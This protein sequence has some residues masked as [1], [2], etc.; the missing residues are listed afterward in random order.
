MNSKQRWDAVVVGAGPNGLSAAVELAHHGGRVLLLEAADRVGGA[1]R[2]EEL[3]LPGFHHDV[4]SA[5]YPL[6][7]GSPFFARLP[8]EEHGLEWIHGSAP[9]AHPLDGGRAVVLER[10][11]RTTALGLGG[12]ARRYGALLDPLVR[13]WPDFAR[14]ILG[15]P[16]TL[17]RDP[18]LMA[19]FG[20]SALWP[21]GAL[22]R[23]RF[24]T[25]EARA[26]FAGN[27]AHAALP[28]DRTPT[29]AIAL[30]LMAAGHAVGW[31]VPRGGAGALTGALASYARSL[32]VAIETGR[33]VAHLSELPPAKSV[34]L[35]LT[36]R[37]VLEVAGDAL[38]DGYRRR[39]EEWRYGP[40]AFK[41]DWALDGPIPWAAD[42]C[43]RA[44][45]IHLGG[46]LR[47]ME[48]AEALPWKGESAERPFVLLAQPTLFDPTR[49]PEGKHTAWAYCHVPNGWR[50]GEEL[51]LRRLE[52]QVERFAPGFRDRIL[53]RSVLG[54]ADLEAWNPNLVGGDIGGGAVT[55]GQTLARPRAFPDPWSTPVPGL[56]ICS[57]ST[58]PG[59]GVH[60]MC[61]YHAARRAIRGKA[62]S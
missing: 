12:D 1:A 53:A 59:P 50:G 20:L 8:L 49:A 44:V 61:G 60:G 18:V 57:S 45:T 58:P 7:V 43:R 17:P 47:E 51:M 48:E 28:L 13:R 10:D 4:G 52:D 15:A 42:A 22:A 56:Y 35:D 16:L 31:P 34:L 24:H 23:R 19:R 25:P 6:G 32:G 33:R 11:V 26:L 40:G 41:V 62:L 9:L 55:L 14:Q 38:P 46:T 39:L 2:T 3:T 5:V 27:A 37:Q 21:A 36:P 30:V 54:P 29:S